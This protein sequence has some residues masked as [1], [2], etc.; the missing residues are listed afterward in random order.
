MNN[1][2]IA[3]VVVILLAGGFLLWQSYTPMLEVVT[4]TPTPITPTPTLTPTPGMPTPA[5]SPATAP[6][7]ATITYNGTSFSPAAVV[8]KKG[9]TVTWINNSTKDMWVASAAH[10]SHTVYAGTSLRD[11]CPDTSGTSF[12]QCAGG[13][14]YSFTFNKAGTWG[15]HDH[16]TPSASGRVEVVE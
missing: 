15:Y 7:S 1:F 3:L 2:L 9:G 10:P 8:I 14:N 12:D 16:I 11:H 5:P 13:A 4:P 6:M